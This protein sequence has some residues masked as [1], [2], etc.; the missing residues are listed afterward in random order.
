M[1]YN[2]KPM[3]NQQKPLKKHRTIWKPRK[4]L[5]ETTQMLENR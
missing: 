4:N 2:Q 3:E 1:E 5:E